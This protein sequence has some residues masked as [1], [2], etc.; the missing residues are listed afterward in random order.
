MIL[1]NRTIGVYQ[2]LRY[3][4]TDIIQNKKLE[5]ANSFL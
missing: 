1:I 5:E 4:I 2:I 3:S